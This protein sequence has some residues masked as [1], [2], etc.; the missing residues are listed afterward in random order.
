MIFKKY[1]RVTEN[2][3]IA[4]SGLCNGLGSR[5]KVEW[6]GNYIVW[7]LDQK[8]DDECLRLACGLISDIASAIGENL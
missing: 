1:K 3:L 8:E 7:A 2:G 4:L 5:I 6:F